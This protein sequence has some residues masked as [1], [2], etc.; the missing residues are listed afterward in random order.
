[1]TT[2]CNFDDI[3]DDDSRAFEV[4]GDSLFAVK[5][6][7]QVYVYRNSCP[8]LGVELNWLEHK[9]L[10]QENALIQCTTHGALFVIESGQCVAGPCMGEALQ[11][12]A[13]KVED[14]KV[15]LV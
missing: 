2:L 13:C 1:M 11:V 9:F 8:H 10:D 6:D 15:I 12:V 4:D 14:G 7:G 5:K 3:P